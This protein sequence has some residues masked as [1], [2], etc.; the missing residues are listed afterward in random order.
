M[1]QSLGEE[2]AKDMDLETSGIC[3]GLN[4]YVP[5]TNSYVKIPTINMMVLAGGPFGGW[6]CHEGEVF[7]NGI[8]ALI[9]ETP[10]PSVVAHTYGPRLPL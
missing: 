8:N 10:R 6:F 7:I 4:V 2:W 5:S 9:K 1:I 3:Y